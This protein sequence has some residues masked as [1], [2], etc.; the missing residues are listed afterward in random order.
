MVLTERFQGGRKEGK[1]GGENQGWRNARYKEGRIIE[2][3]LL[4]ISLW[5][6]GWGKG[7][8]GI[9]IGA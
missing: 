5:L 6:K 9:K 4:L 8:G 1:R 7:G 2:F 3:L